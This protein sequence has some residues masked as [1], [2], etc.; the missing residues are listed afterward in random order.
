MASVL[1][2]KEL[3]AL[4]TITG[5]VCPLVLTTPWLAWL[6]ADVD[7]ECAAVADTA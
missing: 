1:A 6:L 7:L 2:I 3:N 5:F 4:A